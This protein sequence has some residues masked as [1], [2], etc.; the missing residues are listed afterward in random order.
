MYDRMRADFDAL[1]TFM[2]VHAPGASHEGAL[3][4]GDYARAQFDSFIVNLDGGHFGSLIEN[5]HLAGLPALHEAA[6]AVTGAQADAWPDDKVRAVER[7][8][9]GMTSCAAGVTT[10]LSYVARD[11]THA[12]AGMRGKIW[13]V[14]DQAVEAMLVS[15]VNE[16]FEDHLKFQQD[17]I[18][19]SDLGAADRRRQYAGSEI[20]HVN[21]FWDAIADPLGLVKKN[22]PLHVPMPTVDKEVSAEEIKQWQDRIAARLQPSLIALTIADEILAGY[23][24]DV[25]AAGIGLEGARVAASALA[26]VARNASERLGLPTDDTFNLYRLVSFDEASYHV[27]DDSSVLALEI[28]S[29]MDK[30]GLIVGQA[31]DHGHWMDPHGNQVYALLVYQDLAWKVEVPAGTGLSSL[32]WT[33]ADGWEVH[34][35]DWRDLHNWSRSQSGGAAI[36]PQGAL[37]HVIGKTV[38]V[39]CRHGFPAEWFTEQDSHR[40]L[41]DRLG[42]GLAEYAAHLEAWCPA[43]LNILIEECEKKRICL[44]ELFDSYDEQTGKKVLPPVRLVLNC[45]DRTYYMDSKAVLMHWPSHPVIDSWLRTAL[46][47]EGSWVNKLEYGA[48]KA[49][50]RWYRL[51]HPTAP[52]EWPS[53]AGGSA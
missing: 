7:L 39:F 4:R 35:L 14:K 5:V 44:P 26:D 32:S 51:T 48:F 15:Q 29:R 20:H 3:S 23:R 24:A 42:L 21:A 47:T 36:P 9:D 10:N 8:A 34:A 53:R 45:M 37:R 18:R 27:W 6:L 19:I 2:R 40:K 46:R 31:V 1:V 41:R 13:Q 16:W 50:R 17:M 30:L 38:P 33:D 11:M 28:L 49:A 25:Q 12:G 52:T 43:Q 22:D